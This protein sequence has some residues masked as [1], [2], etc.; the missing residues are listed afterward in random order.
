VEIEE[1]E[2]VVTEAEEAVTEVA[3]EEEAEAAE[4]AEAVVLSEKI[5]G[6]LVELFCNFTKGIPTTA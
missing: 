1:V 3:V 2:G 4:A 6:Q 5:L